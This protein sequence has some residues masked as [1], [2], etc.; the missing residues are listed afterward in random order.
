M[1]EKPRSSSHLPPT[2]LVA[3][4]N[5]CCSNDDGEIGEVGRWGGVWKKWKKLVL[6]RSAN[7]AC[8]LFLNVFKAHSGGLLVSFKHCL[9]RK[10]MLCFFQV[11]LGC[12][13]LRFVFGGHLMLSVFALV[14]F[15]HRISKWPSCFKKVMICRMPETEST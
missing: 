13:L 11:F 5:T 15:S 6:S 14:I 10:L 9:L 12:F 3:M 2:R 8:C 4:G 7:F 1:K